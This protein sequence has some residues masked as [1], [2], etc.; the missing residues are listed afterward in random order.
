MTQSEIHDFGVE[1]VFGFLK[2]QNYE[3]DTVNTDITKNPQIVAKRNGQLHFIIVRTACYPSKG[4]IE[5]DQLTLQFIEHAD[6]NK[7]VCYFASV[8]IANSDGKN[9][10]E[11]AIPVK[12]AGYYVSFDGLEILTLNA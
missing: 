10:L 3:I 8:G 4:K 5:S 11:M 6:K 9:D 12:G 2:K 7:A 1:A